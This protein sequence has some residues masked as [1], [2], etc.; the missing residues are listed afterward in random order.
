VGKQAQPQPDYAGLFTGM[1]QAQAANNQY[2]LGQQQLDWAKQV[3]NQNEPYIQQASQESLTAQQNA[4]TFAKGQQ[5]LYTSTY[6]PLQQKY[7]QQVQNWDTPQTE[8]QNAGAAQEMV[9]DQFTQARNSAASQLESFGVDPSSTRYA[10]LDIGTRTQQAAAEA[11]QGTQAIQNTK[12][13]GMGLEAGAISQGQGLPNQSAALS[14]AGTGAG[15]A[16]SSGLTSAYGTGAGAM[17]GA[18]AWFNSGNASMA[19]AS[20]TFGS[21]YNGYNSAMNAYANQSSGVGAGLGFLGGIASAGKGTGLLA[22]LEDGGEVPAQ[23]AIPTPQTGGYVPPHASPSGGQVTDDINARLN[24][25]EF[26]IPREVVSWEGEKAIHKFIDKARADR[27]QNEATTQ[28]KPQMRPAIPGP[29]R[30]VS[31]QGAIPV[32]RA[33]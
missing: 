21:A 19:G 32:P 3:Y 16:S 17:N 1:A 15:S 30:F 10:A 20:S 22:S 2:Q 5:D 25:G 13:Q 33:A 14:G 8:L 28:T 6:E 31:G 29:A 26:V 7:A 11:G 18:N 4:D 12:L 27:A 24:A 23:G 9:S